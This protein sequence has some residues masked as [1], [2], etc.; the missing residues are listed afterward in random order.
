MFYY[1]MIVFFIFILLVCHVI[2]AFIT[3]Y[4]LEDINNK[5]Y[6]PSYK[7]YMLIPGIPELI[8]STLMIS[9]FILVIYTYTINLFKNKF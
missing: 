4:L 7:K 5:W 1:L 3:N 2:I 8:L 6:K 9:I